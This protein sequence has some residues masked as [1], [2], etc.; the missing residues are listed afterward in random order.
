MKFAL[1]TLNVNKTITRNRE[2]IFMIILWHG[3]DG[4]E[5]KIVTIWV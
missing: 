3:F 4:Y 5:T 1:Y 2:I